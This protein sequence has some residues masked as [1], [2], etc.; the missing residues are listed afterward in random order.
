MRLACIAMCMIGCG[1]V[2]SDEKVDAMPDSPKPIDAMIDSPVTPARCNPNAA[3]GAPVAVTELNTTGYEEG[4]S[5]SP[6]ELTIYFASLRTGGLG[7]ND[8]WVATR[9]SRDAP[10]GAP[11]LL[12]GVNTTANENWPSVT[13]DGLHL[14]VSTLAQ[15]WDIHAAQRANTTSNFG[16][17]APVASLNATTDEIY[18]SILPDHSA[19]YFEAIR[20][21]TDRDLYRAARNV[22]GTF[23]AAAEI[24]S[25]STAMD[26][27]TPVLTPDELTL[28]F[29]SNRPGGSGAFDIWVAKR[30]TA[31]DGFGT[32]TAVAALNSSAE[33]LPTWVSADGCVLHFA[34]GSG[35]AIDLYVAKRGM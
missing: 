14:Y 4:G 15:S 19:I 18:Q 22:G 35:N 7:G 24:T 1:S 33:E 12:A 21:G 29:S 17:H 5:L 28:F 32:A 8:I 13:A 30:S 34:R 26:E 10:F 25:V 3:F 20:G 27:K 16:A 9:A 2:K 23:D 6:D 31:S 11:A